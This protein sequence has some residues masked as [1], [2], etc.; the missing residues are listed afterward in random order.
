VPEHLGQE[1]LAIA[2]EC[3]VTSRLQARGLVWATALEHVV[4]CLRLE[5]E[6]DTGGDISESALDYALVAT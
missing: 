2:Y 6:G 5:F 3:P 1:K 4:V